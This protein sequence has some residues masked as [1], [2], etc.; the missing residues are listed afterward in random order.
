MTNPQWSGLPR[1]RTYQADCP[2]KD[3]KGL[4]D[5]RWFLHVFG[6]P[7]ADKTC[8]EALHNWITC[9]GYTVDF[10]LPKLRISRTQFFFLKGF[11]HPR[12]P[13]PSSFLAGG[14]RVSA[15]ALDAFLKKSVGQ[16]CA[17]SIHRLVYAYVFTHFFSL[18]L[19]IYHIYIYY[20]I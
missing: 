13:I 7:F 19:F 11:S 9:C 2:Q 18:S 15:P 12:R 4:Q 3:P 5:F 14:A 16:K 17:P 6:G 8:S 10:Q 1:L 20:Y